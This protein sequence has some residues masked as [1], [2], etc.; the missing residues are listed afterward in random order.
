[1]RG[2][3]TAPSASP[4]SS[5]S[6]GGSPHGHGCSLCPASLCK[7]RELRAVRQQGAFRRHL[8]IGQGSEDVC[9]AMQLGPE[10]CVLARRGHALA[11]FLER[12]AQ[13]GHPG[14]RVAA[15][16]VLWSHQDELR[17]AVQSVL[18][19]SPQGPSPSS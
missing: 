17:E 1:M 10:D 9:P 2:A 19:S 7:G 4:S 12:C 11:A 16:V 18:L 8:L 15:R 6:S 13:P 3:H 14:P 5:S